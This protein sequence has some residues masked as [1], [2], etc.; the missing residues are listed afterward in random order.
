MKTPPIGRRFPWSNSPDDAVALHDAGGELVATYAH[1][2]VLD[3][4]GA[5]VPAR[6]GVGDGRIAVAVDDADAQYPLVVDPLLVAE[7]AMLLP[8]G[9]RVER[10]LRLLGRADV[11]REP[12]ARRRA[13]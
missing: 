7:E 3:A 4:S 6:I 12:R 1:L 13:L 11:G 10:Q 2:I 8:S 9:G 5:R